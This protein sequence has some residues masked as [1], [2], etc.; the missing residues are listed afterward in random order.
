MPWQAFSRIDAGFAC[1]RS[2]ITVAARNPDHLDL[3]IF[4]ETE[5]V[6]AAAAR[7]LSN[8]RSVWFIRSSDE[9]LDAANRR[10]MLHPL[11][12]TI[13]AQQLPNKGVL[14]QSRAFHSIESH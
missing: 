8:S 6:S 9:F 13:V 11:G 10:E 7:C 1:G 12:C 3:F 4:I 2:P 14:H 5:M